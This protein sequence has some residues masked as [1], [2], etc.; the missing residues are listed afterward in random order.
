MNITFG[1]GH[2]IINVLEAFT[3]DMTAKIFRKLLQIK[4]IS[5]IST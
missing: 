2:I 3:N 4:L 5:H 1:S